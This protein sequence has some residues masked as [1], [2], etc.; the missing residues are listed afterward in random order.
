[1]TTYYIPKVG[2]VAG[3]FNLEGKSYPRNWLQ[4][5]TEAEKAKIGAKAPPS[6]DQATQ[7]LVKGN[8]GWEVKDIPQSELDAKAA[9]E[10][11]AD[12]RYANYEADLAAIK[13]AYPSMNDIQKAIIRV[14]KYKFEDIENTLDA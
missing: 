11:E 10:S 13:A 9:A 12:T 8:D 14:L 6:Y 2:Y 1:M 4:L 3:A 7:R 5:A